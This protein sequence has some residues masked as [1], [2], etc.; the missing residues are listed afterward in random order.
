MRYMVYVKNKQHKPPLQIN[1]N[2]KLYHI[3][4][5]DNTNNLIYKAA[6]GRNFRGAEFQVIGKCQ[7]TTG[8]LGYH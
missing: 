6:F 4:C 3:S 1:N 2:T 7:I 8:R 5:R